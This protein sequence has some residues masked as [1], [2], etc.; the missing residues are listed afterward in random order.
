MIGAETPSNAEKEDSMLVVPISEREFS[1]YALSLPY[2]PNFDPYLFESGWK[3]QAGGIAGAI[4]ID[5]DSSTFGF[6]VMRRRVDH[7]WVL[8][9]QKLGL[10]SQDGALA[11]LTEKMG[12][13]GKPEPL[14]PGKKRRPSILPKATQQTSE[15]F[16]LLTQTI[17]HRPA[18]MA[19]GEVYF[20]MPNPDDNFARDLQ[21]EN[22]DSRIFELYLLAC[23]REQGLFV[24]QDHV[25]PD[26]LIK[27]DGHDCYVE[28]VTANATNRSAKALTTPIFAP[29]SREERLTGAPAVRFAKTLRSKLQREYEVLP[30]VA[31][32]P[33]ALA[34][35]DFHAPSSMVWSREALPSY[36]FGI[37][38]DVDNGPD[39]AKAIGTTIN[40]LLGEDEIPAGLFRDPSMSYL[41]GIIFSNAATIAKFNRMGYLAGWRPEGLRMIREG[42]L[43]D[44]TPGAL[45]PI[46]FSLDILSEEYSS[47][48]R[49]GEAWCQE[50]DVFHN[51]LAERPIAF[52]LLPGAT[53]WFESEGEI[54]CSTIWEN[55]V[56]A[57]MTTL[58]MP[59]PKQ[60]VAE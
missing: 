3:L 14:L 56:L 51:P 26:F 30:H 37:K 33:F 29:A 1:L 20:A 11:K 48:W 15:I 53:H 25:S 9:E 19:V 24:G 44:R 12:E 43:F 35:A 50:L 5:P 31:G 58:K 16:K 60:T 27:R 7:C 46:D 54:I 4:L 36:L 28:A 45:E 22:F 23:F 18:L 55:S 47:L 49:G 21:T 59:K 17:T 38:A 10:S 8:K 41:S 34:I 2:G 32:K 6:V 42:I 57:S 13:D 40:K 39:G 52:D